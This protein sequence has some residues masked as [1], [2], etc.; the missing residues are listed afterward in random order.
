MG[1][2][3]ADEGPAMFALIESSLP[4]KP[5]SLKYLNSLRQAFSQET[6]LVRPRGS[7]PGD[8]AEPVSQREVEVLHL[9]SLGY[10]NQ[11]IGRHRV[12]SVSTVKTHVINFFGKLGVKSRT[13]AVARAKEIKLLD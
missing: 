10:S 4:Y 13:E 1:Q 12:I 6:N 8:L 9:I 3:F 5:I 11:E 7:Q 2:S